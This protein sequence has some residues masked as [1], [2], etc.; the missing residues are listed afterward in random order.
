MRA[1]VRVG[2]V[3]RTRRLFGL[4]NPLSMAKLRRR[5]HRRPLRTLEITLQA[6]QPCIQ[7]LGG[8]RFRHARKTELLLQRSR[9]ILPIRTVTSIWTKQ[10]IRFPL[11]AT[12]LNEKILGLPPSEVSP[13][14][15]TTSHPVTAEPSSPPIQDPLPPPSPH[16]VPLPM[17]PSPT[18]IARVTSL[19][20]R[21][22]SC[23]SS[24]HLRHQFHV[25][26]VP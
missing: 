6:A 8:L 16:T 14:P 22:R 7:L 5:L 9:S 11:N 12:P 10:C 26:R 13:P 1:F 18:P 23:L 15:F 3:E 4:Q 21:P 17:M 20:L 2:I 25:L 19:C 24:S